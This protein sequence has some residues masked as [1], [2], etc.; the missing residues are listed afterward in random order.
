MKKKKRKRDGPRGVFQ[1]TGKDG[2]VSWG[3]DYAHPITGARIRKILP[4]VHTEEKALKIRDMEILDAERG[5]DKAYGL[6]DRRKNPTFKSVLEL[7]L[8]WSRQ[9]KRSWKTDEH[10]A[11]ALRRGFKGRTMRD[12]TPFL[13]DRYKAR[14]IEEVS[15]NTVNKELLLGGQIFAYAISR[16][17][18]DGVNP[19]R[20]VERFRLRK[21][22]KPGCLTPE[23]VRRI[24]DAIE[25]PVKRDMVGFAYY[26]GW[27]IGEI[28]RL[29]WEDVDLEAGTA[30]IVDPK[31]A[32]SVNVLLSGEALRIVRRQERGPAHVFHKRSGEPYRT[33][34]DALIPRAAARAGVELP[35]GKRW[36][37]FRRTWASM[38]LQSGCDVETL[39]VMGNW[40][41]AGM[42]LWYAEAAGTDA[43][44]K[45]LARLPSL[46]AVKV[47]KP[48]PGGVSKVTSLADYRKK[49]AAS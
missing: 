7:Y 14:R 37:I 29:K 42:P 18:Y 49:R 4:G 48:A 15:K 41:D 45:I 22:K 12:V 21:G 32:N 23:E 36:H 43:R 31:N 28:R 34:L 20:E 27:R 35:A 10:R 6:K 33:N 30:W 47:E 1:R 40:K 11:S 19:F 16:D 2:T 8:A 25:D 9:H 5:L 44:K 38:M 26:T 3:I 24:Q 46:E 13:V 17:L 39:R